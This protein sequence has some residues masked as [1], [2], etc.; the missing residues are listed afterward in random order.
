M[1]VTST[2]MLALKNKDNTFILHNSKVN[3]CTSPDHQLFITEKDDIFYVFFA[4][5]YVLFGQE[6]HAINQ[7]AI[8]PW[9]TMIGL[10]LF[11]LYNSLDCQLSATEGWS[12]YGLLDDLHIHMH[13]TDGNNS[14]KNQGDVVIL[15]CPYFTE[16]LHFDT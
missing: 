14:V 9:I 4:Q 2:G 3:I 8:L 1:Q 6:F 13:K 5:Y 12:Q 7:G 11:P 15:Q 10:W 16:F